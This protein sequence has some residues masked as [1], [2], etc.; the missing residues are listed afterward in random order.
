MGI[1]QSPPKE[2]DGAPKPSGVTGEDSDTRQDKVERQGWRLYSH[3][4][5][6][7]FSGYLV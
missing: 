2:K 5:P 6:H 3:M 1:S 7:P 4:N